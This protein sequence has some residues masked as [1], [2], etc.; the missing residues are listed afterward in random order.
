MR[1]EGDDGLVC[2]VLLDGEDISDLCVAADDEEGWVE[3]YEVVRER[4]DIPR[5]VQL[6]S[7]KIAK[8][9]ILWSSPDPDDPPQWAIV[10]W[11]DADPTCPEDMQG[12]ARTLVYGQVTI[13]LTGRRVVHV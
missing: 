2:K 9:W 11:L 10:R 3:V 1:V 13:I 12:L 7:G 4:P 6:K 5:T 8:A